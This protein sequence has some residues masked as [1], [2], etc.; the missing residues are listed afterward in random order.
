MINRVVQ[1]DAK[2]CGIACVA[3]VTGQDYDTVKTG[4]E[5]Y[6][7]D[8]L[9]DFA[10]SAY[11]AEHGYAT[12]IKYPHYMPTNTKREIFPPE[13]FADV[14]LVSAD[15]HNMVMLRDGTILDPAPS[16]PEPRTINQYS[17]VYWVMAVVKIT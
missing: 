9:T 6:F 3:M 1:K 16:R 12:A 7:K 10:I 4:F 8:G 2:G 14:H 17:F 5:G 11:L 13:P 15:G